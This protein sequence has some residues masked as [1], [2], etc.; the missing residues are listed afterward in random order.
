MKNILLTFLFL[1]MTVSLVLAL[2]PDVYDR[3]KPSFNIQLTEGRM[4]DV[5]MVTVDGHDEAYTF[6][7][8]EPLG[9]VLLS[10]GDSVRLIVR[11]LEKDTTYCLY[12]DEEKV[13]SVKT[14]NNGNANSGR[15]DDEFDYSDLYEMRDVDLGAPIP[16]LEE[17]ES[18]KFAIYE[19]S[20]KSDFDDVDEEDLVLMGAE[21]KNNIH[22]EVPGGDQG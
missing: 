6:I 11:H 13:L 15:M 7:R 19:G 10:R 14:N 8:G 20:C 2:S 16:T 22:E 5:R 3:Y 18:S 4:K 17:G 1:V 12:Y 21:P 9:N